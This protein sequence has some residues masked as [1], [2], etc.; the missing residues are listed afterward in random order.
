MSI[1]KKRHLE[2]MIA[3]ITAVTVILAVTVGLKSAPSGVFTVHKAGTAVSVAGSEMRTSIPGTYAARRIRG[4]AVTDA[5]VNAEARLG[6]RRG[7]TPYITVS[8]TE[9]REHPREMEQLGLIVDAM[10]SDKVEAV[11]DISLEARKKGKSIRASHGSVYVTVGLSVRRAFEE[12][13]YVI[14]VRPD[15]ELVVMRDVD[16][17]PDT[18]TFDVRAGAGVYAVVTKRI[19]DKSGPEL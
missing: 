2:G 7:Q 16:S 14:C 11:L 10:E 3:V 15:G 4:A 12:A 19:P 6:L 18:V 8:D 5:Y 17:N 13:A 9:V 1:Q